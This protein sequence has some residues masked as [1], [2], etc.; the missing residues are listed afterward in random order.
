[1]KEVVSI[2][3]GTVDAAVK[4]D[5]DQLKALENSMATDES[6]SMPK[7]I[8]IPDDDEALSDIVSRGIEHQTEYD[9]ISDVGLT[10]EIEVEGVGKVAVDIPPVGR[11]HILPA[12]KSSGSTVFDSG[13]KVIKTHSEK[14]PISVP[15]HIRDIC[16][17]LQR[18]VDKNEFSIVCKGQ[19]IDGEYIVSEDY[20]VP[21]QVVAG[22]SVDYDLEHLEALKLAGYNTVIHSHPFKSANFSSSDEETIN[23]HFECSILYSVGEFPTATIAISSTPGMKFILTGDP[24]IDHP[25]GL[26]P[27][28]EVKNIDIKQYASTYNNLYNGNYYDGWNDLGHNLGSRNVKNVGRNIIGSDPD[29]C[30]KEYE[31]SQVHNRDVVRTRNFVYDVDEDHL[32]YRGGKPIHKSQSPRAAAKS[33]ARNEVRIIQP[34]KV[35]SQCGCGCHNAAG[36]PESKVFRTE[37]HANQKVFRTA[38][39]PKTKDT[40]KHKNNKKNR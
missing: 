16:D 18:K 17:S 8:I 10:T 39:S 40:I 34:V 1:M 36:V 12:K 6:T 19:W 13:L 26:V 14:I 20:K 30:E 28:D 5:I 22:A 29:E 32:T 23:S 25:D 4:N 9:A 27:E 11:V 21:K 2:E 33:A 35:H 24:Q 7:K 3:T 31:R 38:D 15:V 37:V